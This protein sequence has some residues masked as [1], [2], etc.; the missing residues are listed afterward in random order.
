MCLP[1]ILPLKRCVKGQNLNIQQ[2]NK[3][4]K[5]VEVTHRIELGSSMSANE[6]GEAFVQAKTIAVAALTLIFS[7]GIVVA[8][9]LNPKDIVRPAGTKPASMPAKEALALGKKL[10]ADEKLSTNG[11]SCM[12]CHADFGAFNDTFKKP[13][14]HF[15]QMGDDAAGL[16]AVTAENMVQLCMIAPMEASPLP[17]DSRELRSLTS[18]VE[19]LRTEFSKKK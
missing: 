15:V 5:A 12:S 6:F 14:P 18:Y 10:Y 16:K 8:Q 9:N 19:L 17:W 2:R 7:T 4:D 13:F 3:A 11:M 1:R